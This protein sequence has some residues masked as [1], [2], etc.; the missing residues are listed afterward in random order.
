MGTHKATTREKRLMSDGEHLGTLTRDLLANERTYL[1][2]L[3]TAV[4]L[5]VVGLAV[6]RLL[7][8][9]HRGPLVAGILLIAVGAVGVVYATRRSRT[10]AALIE[11]GDIAG[12]DSGR[13]MTIVSSVLV[14]TVVVALVLLL[15]L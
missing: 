7:D 12:R 9:G 5:M 15:L 4:S 1:A 13:A 14:L 10:A 3:R 8:P 11:R 6:A 2:W